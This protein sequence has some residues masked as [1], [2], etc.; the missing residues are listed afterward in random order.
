M[1]V[2]KKSFA[3]LY[4]NTVRAPWY[5]PWMKCALLWR[6]TLPACRSSCR[7]LQT[8]S[9]SSPL[10]H[11]GSWRGNVWAAMRWGHMCRSGCSHRPPQDCPLL[12]PQAKPEL[13]AA[14]RRAQCHFKSNLTWVGAKAFTLYIL[15]GW[16]ILTELSIFLGV[17]AMRTML[18]AWGHIGNINLLHSLPHF[19]VPDCSILFI[20]FHQ[21]SSTQRRRTVPPNNFGSLARSRLRRGT[22]SS[23]AQEDATQKVKTERRSIAPDVKRS[24]ESSATKALERQTW[25]KMATD[26]IRKSIIPDVLAPSWSAI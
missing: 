18:N 6:L 16:L 7:S 19:I 8:C 2:C 3:L 13:P 5:G 26:T 9:A 21:V 11:A 22:S 20:V 17:G 25:A 4:M 12:E 15:D 23:D 14:V 10:H 24:I 1:L